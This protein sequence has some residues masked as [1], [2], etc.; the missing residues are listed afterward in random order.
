[1]D[2]DG[3]K[4][5]LPLRLTSSADELGIQDLG[6]WILDKKSP[7]PREKVAAASGPRSWIHDPSGF[8]PPYPKSIPCARGRSPDQLIVTVWRR[9]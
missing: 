7:D 8:W 2:H 9:M 5:R 6:S 3:T 1:M 4:R